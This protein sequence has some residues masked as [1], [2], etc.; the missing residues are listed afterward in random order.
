METFLQQ[1]E[2]VF[3]K[4]SQTSMKKLTKQNEDATPVLLAVMKMM[5]LMKKMKIA[6]PLIKMT[7]MVTLTSKVMKRIQHPALR[8]AKPNC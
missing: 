4:V 2:P 6:I 8:D 1:R 5:K 3:D 7:N